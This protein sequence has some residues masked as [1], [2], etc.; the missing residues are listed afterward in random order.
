MAKITKTFQYGKHTVTLETGEVARQASGAVIVKMDDTVLLVTAV[1][2]KSAREGQDFFPLTV[3]YQ[4]KF[5]AGGRIPGGFFKREGRATEKETLISRLI[6]RPIRPLFPEDYKNEVQIIATVMSLNPDVD[7]DIPALIGASAA[8]ALAGTPFMGP[9]GAAKVGYKNGEY[10]LNPTVSELADSQLELVVAGT[11]NAVLMV[12]SEAALLSEEVMLGAVTFGHREM[13]KVINAI[14]ELTVEAG[15]KPSTWEAPAKNDALISALKEAIG[16]RLGEA[17][18]VRDK[19]QRRDAISAIKKDV[20][21][22]LAG[23]VAAEGWNPAEL[24]KEFG[25]LEYRTMRDSV[26]DT[27]VRIDGRAL[28]TVRPIAV[29][30]GVLPR[31]HGSSLFTRGETQAIVTIT[32]GTAR[33]GQVIDAVAG[34]YKENFLF[35]YNFPPFSVGECGRM[36]GPKRREIGHGRLAKRGV[37]AV[38]PSLEAFPYTI[39]VVSEIT[40]SNGSSSM[41]S[42]CGSSLALMDAGVP[43]KAPVAGIAMGLVKEG[44]RFV[45]LSDILGD[46]DHLGDMDFK[47][48][49][50]AEGISALQMDIKIEGITEEIMKQALQQAKAGRLHILGEM[51]HG[52]TAPRSELSDYAP[53]LLTIKIHPDKIREVIGKGGSTIQAITKETGT[54]ID[55]QDDGTIVIASVNAIAAQAAK[56]RIEQI[57]SDVEPGRIYEGKVAKIMDFGAFVTILPGKDGLVHVSQISSDRVEKV[58]DVL[59]EGDVV[60]V[61]VLEVDKQGR[62]RLSMKAVEEGDAVS[63]E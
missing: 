45:V 25:E 61:K 32:L 56:A 55:I 14:N 49:G 35:H 23:R 29:K 13:Q 18:Q 15:T 8:L 19:L 63:A 34:E 17:F 46:E 54:Q 53:R 33:D 36:M 21:E 62:I 11:S 3:D 48:A 22:T 27:K 4:E 40:E 58:G 57:T 20:V 50:T 37:L 12:E 28:D 47:V 24:S 60:K 31:T 38:M 41:A 39:R 7:G 6:D 30:T 1:A 52:L 10:I 43:V 9:I 42:V 2:A 16:P 5:Y 51:A 44:E 59:K 26:L